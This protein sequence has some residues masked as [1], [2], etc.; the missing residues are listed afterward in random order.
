MVLRQTECTSLDPLR[1]TRLLPLMFGYAARTAGASDA[2]GA[3]ESGGSHSPLPTNELNREQQRWRLSITILIL[4]FSSS[5]SSSSIPGSRLTEVTPWGGGDAGG[6]IRTA[7]TGAGI[8]VRRR[9]GAD[10]DT[11]TDR[12]LRDFSCDETDKGPPLQ[13]HSLREFEQVRAAGK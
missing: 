5:S 13:M 2:G 9:D 8:P 4:I 7:V 6:W 3:G 11:D 1:V 12:E 10:T